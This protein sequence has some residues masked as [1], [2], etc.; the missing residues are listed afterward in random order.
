MFTNS[1]A[2]GKSYGGGGA[3]AKE[4]MFGCFLEARHQGSEV[5]VGSQGWERKPRAHSELEVKACS[6]TRLTEQNFTA[7][8]DPVKNG[9]EAECPRNLLRCPRNLQTSVGKHDPSFMRNGFEL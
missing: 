4:M 8:W 3:I 5:E 6:M 9:R 7:T 2:S 1:A